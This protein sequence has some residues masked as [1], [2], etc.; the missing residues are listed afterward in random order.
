MEVLIAIQLGYGMAQNILDHCGT[1]A[2]DCLLSGQV[3]DQDNY[4]CAPIHISA[5]SVD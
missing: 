2:G 3:W 1:C 4:V 5:Y